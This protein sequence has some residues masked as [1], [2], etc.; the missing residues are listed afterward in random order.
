MQI[1]KALTVVGVVVGIVAQSL[2]VARQL[3][4]NDEE[5]EETE[6]D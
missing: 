1:I 4:E 6:E 2:S 3:Q 5:Y